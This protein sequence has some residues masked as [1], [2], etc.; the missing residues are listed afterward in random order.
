MT[1]ELVTIVNRY[2]LRAGAG[3]FVLAVTA[4]AR[5]VE[6]EGHPGVLAYRFYAAPDA[7][8]G[9]AVVLY[10]D[11]EAWV[12]HHDIAMGWPE[13]AALRAVA[14]L[15][16]IAVHGPLSGGMRRW[17]EISGMM[18][19]VRHVGPVVAGFVRPAR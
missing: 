9:R 11:P 17:M 19:K 3:Q 2:A 12:G 13:M 18:P 16:E 4:L 15:V 7:E 5:R 10:A 1:G 14:D 6:A 8:E